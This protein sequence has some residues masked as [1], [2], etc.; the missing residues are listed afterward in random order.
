MQF[1]DL[2]EEFEL[3]ATDLGSMSLSLSLSMA[4]SEEEVVQDVDGEVRLRGAAERDSIKA[5]S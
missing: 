1:A 4:S 3:S 5:I 2:A